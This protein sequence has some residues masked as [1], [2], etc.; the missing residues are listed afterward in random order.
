MR[1]LLNVHLTDYKTKAITGTSD[2][3][4][5]ELNFNS[6]DRNTVSI[7][8]LFGGYGFATG[9]AWFDDIELVKAH[10]AGLAGAE[11]KVLGIVTAHYA[12]RGPVESVVETLAALKNSDPALATVMLEGLVAGWPQGVAPK[13]TEADAAQLHAVMDALPSAAR[14]RML[15]LSERWGRQDLFAKE[16]AAVIQELQAHLVNE[17]M[18]TDERIDAARRLVGVKDS[19]ETLSAIID[20]ITPQAAPELQV[21]LLN[22]ISVSRSANV[23]DLIVKKWTKLTPTAQRT[24]LGVLLRRPTW[25]TALLDGVEAGTVNTKD[26]RR[27]LANPD[28]QQGHRHRRAGQKTRAIQRPSRRS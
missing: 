16:A 27:A 2:W 11:G 5:V 1:A 15:A 24:A 3:Q 6:G 10:S 8:C 12:Q 19:P 21:G 23:G 22:T 4:K 28:A 13:L 9:T 26:L 18:G 20:Q 25:A 7:N 14:D 17:K